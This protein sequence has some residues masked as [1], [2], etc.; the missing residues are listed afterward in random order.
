MSDAA[1]VGT[2][3]AP[4]PFDDPNGDTILRTPDKVN[5]HVH[6][7]VLRLSSSVFDVMFS[8]PQPPSRADRTSTVV[9][10][11]VDMAEDS[12]VLYQLLSW[13]D[14]RGIPSPGDL[15]DIGAVLACAEKY[16]VDAVKSRLLAFVYAGRESLKQHPIGL[17]A[18]GRHFGHQDIV[19]FAARESLRFPITEWSDSPLLDLITG[20]DYRLLVCYYF[21]CQIV[22]KSILKDWLRWPGYKDYIWNTPRSQHNCTSTVHEGITYPDW[23]VRYLEAVGKM[24]WETPCRQKYIPDLQSFNDLLVKQLGAMLPKFSAFLSTTSHGKQ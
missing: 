4:T 18:L 9:A 6:T 3:T 19:E 5:F 8:L 16:G 24:L 20:R 21:H 14:P 15:K 13:V 17:F 1:N 7:S 22:A 2:T 23:W 11:V 12:K 10:N